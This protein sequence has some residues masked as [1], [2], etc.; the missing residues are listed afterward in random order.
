MARGDQTM[1]TREALAT[2]RTEPVRDL[3]QDVGS[4]AA[5]LLDH[6]A[7]PSKRK[8]RGKSA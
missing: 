2:P 5:L 1:V 7:E 6:L 4:R 3:T 8:R